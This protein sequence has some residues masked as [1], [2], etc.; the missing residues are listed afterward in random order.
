MPN[1]TLVLLIAAFIG[2]NWRK[3][4]QEALD[5]DYKFLSYGD[6]SLLIP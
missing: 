4:Y 1:S 3:V 5:N 2:E 6:S